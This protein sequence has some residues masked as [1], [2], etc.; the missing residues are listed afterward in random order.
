MGPLQVV[1]RVRTIA[2]RLTLPKGTNIHPAFHVSVVGEAFGANRPILPIPKDVDL[3][4]S[5]KLTLRTVI[6][7]KNNRWI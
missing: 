2:Y 3:D 4:L 5:L 6:G 1:E 7:M